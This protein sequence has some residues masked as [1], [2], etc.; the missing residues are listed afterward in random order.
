[1]ELE[2]AWEISMKLSGIS[3]KLSR[4]SISQAC[5]DHF[6]EL[7]LRISLGIFLCLLGPFGFSAKSTEYY[8]IHRGTLEPCAWW[9]SQH[10]NELAWCMGPRD[11]YHKFLYKVNILSSFILLCCIYISW[12]G[13]ICLIKERSKNL[14]CSSLGY[15]YPRETF[16][17]FIY[18]YNISMAKSSFLR[19]RLFFKKILNRDSDGGRDQESCRKLNMVAC[20]VPK[21]G[22]EKDDVFTL[23]RKLNTVAGSPKK[24]MILRWFG[25]WGRPRD[26]REG[27]DTRLHREA[28]HAT[29]KR[30]WPRNLE[31]RTATQLVREEVLLPEIRTVHRRPLQGQQ[32]QKRWLLPSHHVPHHDQKVRPEIQRGQRGDHQSRW[33]WEQRTAW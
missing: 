32:P 23:I 30:G 1:M 16:C 13:L 19:K 33:F 5:L 17:P 31:E 8:Y 9:G 22:Q 11:E 3:L 6:P 20:R 21:N 18:E 14:W 27:T 26:F 12:I 10:R 4:T 25:K 7:F 28:E 24:T 15:L 29:W 2:L